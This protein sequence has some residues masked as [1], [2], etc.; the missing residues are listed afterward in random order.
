MCRA[1]VRDVCS[2]SSQS[3]YSSTVRT[4]MTRRVSMET[5]R[6]NRIS[7]LRMSKPS[8]R[9]MKTM[10]TAARLMRTSPVTCHMSDGG[11]DVFEYDIRAISPCLGQLRLGA[12]GPQQQRGAQHAPPEGD[13]FVR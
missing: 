5:R 13:E 4:P 10:T 1:S 11:P 12:H 2:S 6:L 3:V 9:V 8:N 7:R